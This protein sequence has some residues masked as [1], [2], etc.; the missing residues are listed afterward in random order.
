MNLV[1][2]S[3][4][5]TFNHIENEVWRKFSPLYAQVGK[6]LTE[7]AAMNFLPFHCSSKEC[8]FRKSQR[9][10][11]LHKIDMP[12]HFLPFC[13]VTTKSL[14]QFASLCLLPSFLMIFRFCFLRFSIYLR[15]KTIHTLSCSL[16]LQSFATGLPV[17]RSPVASKNR[18]RSK[19]NLFWICGVLS[20]PSAVF[21]CV[22]DLFPEVPSHQRC[23]FIFLSATRYE[24]S[25][26]Q[27]HSLTSLKLFK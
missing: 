27:H 10:L 16:I 8:L 18:V 12:I 7:L 5:N 24:L 14:T 4:K 25:K 2:N 13:Y 19:I 26:R 9:D 21:L 17:S 23:I 20:G 1:W 6:S 15:R 11:S 3:G 22:L